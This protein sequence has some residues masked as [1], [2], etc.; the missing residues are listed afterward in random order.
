MEL[1]KLIK[2]AGIELMKIDVTQYIKDTFYMAKLRPHEHGSFSFELSDS[3]N[4][5]SAGNLINYYGSGICSNGQISGLHIEFS[6][7]FTYKL[8]DTFK[9]TE[10]VYFFKEIEDLI[11]S[12]L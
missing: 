8:E 2:D 10:C 11:S 6:H 1:E 5:A 9:V 12:Y 4:H 3:E 7:D